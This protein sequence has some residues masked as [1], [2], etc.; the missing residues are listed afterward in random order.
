MK[1]PLLSALPALFV[2]VGVACG[3]SQPPPPTSSETPPAV[4]ETPPTSSAKTTAGAPASTCGLTVYGASDDPSCQKMLDESC[5]DA[6]KTCAADADCK[7]LLAKVNACPLRKGAETDA[8]LKKAFANGSST[9][10]YSVLNRIST[11]LGPKAPAGS[12][13]SWP[14]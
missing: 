9:P 6:E 13:C 10:G 8:C 1:T 4:S 5:C 14:R 11:C 12:T 7:A 2:L 3:G